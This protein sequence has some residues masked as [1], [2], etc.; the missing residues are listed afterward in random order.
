[1]KRILLADDDAEMRRLLASVLKSAGY[2]VEEAG[3][4]DDLRARLRALEGQF[5]LLVTDVQ[6]PGW[7]GLQALEWTK[8]HNPDVE[9]ILITAFGDPDL[10]ARAA[11]LGA[12]A[13]LDKPFD[14]VTLKQ[15]VASLPASGAVTR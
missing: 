7:T 8:R 5:D 1:M 11:A 9:V 12:R 6:M 4:G 13:V 14:L 3:D 2:R 15:V 10:H